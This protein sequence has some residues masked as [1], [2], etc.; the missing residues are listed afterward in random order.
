[1]TIITIQHAVDAILAAMAVQP[2][3]VTVDTFKAGDPT[4]PLT[5]IVTTFLATAEV[6]ARAAELGANLIITHEPTFYRHDDATTW[7]EDDAVYQ[8]KR[9]LIDAHRIAIW[10]CHDYWHLTQPDGIIVGLVQRLGWT[11]DRPALSAA[12]ARHVLAM[13]NGEGWN[14]ELV[15]RYCAI[16]TIPPTSLARLARQLKARL[17]TDIVRVSGPDDLLCRRVGLTVGA[18]PGSVAIATLMR[19]D[20]DALLC[21]EVREWEACEYLRDAAFFGRPK[22]MVVVGHAASEEDGM[23]YL[24]RWLRPLLPGIPITHVPCGHSLRVIT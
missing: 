23:A 13:T 3:P 18:L 10:R 20:V 24:A 2:L 7:L 22:G 11:L 6:I 16:A 9:R 17:G 15:S 5:G 14:T 1:M 8:A 4:R 21:G 12:A 19:D